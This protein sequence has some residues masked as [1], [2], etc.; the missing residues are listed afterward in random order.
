MTNVALDMVN[1]P[2]SEKNFFGGGPNPKR[3]GRDL[4]DW[5][6]GWLAEFVD[7]RQI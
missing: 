1:S 6:T 7:I 5:K 4:T 3:G 2:Q